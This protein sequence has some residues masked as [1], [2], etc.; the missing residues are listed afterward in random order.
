M[1]GAVRQALDCAPAARWSSRAEANPRKVRS[2]SDGDLQVALRPGFV[3]CDGDRRFAQGGGRNGAAR[4][5][6]DPDAR[7]DH[8]ADGLEAAHLNAYVEVTAEALRR[9]W[10]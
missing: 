2:F 5:Q 1:G 6:S 3:E 7:T 4:D 8:P 9:R 10:W